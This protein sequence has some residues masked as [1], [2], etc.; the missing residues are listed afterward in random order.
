MTGW[1]SSYKK[2]AI[3]LRKWLVGFFKKN[4]IGNYLTIRTNCFSSYKIGYFQV[5]DFFSSLKQNRFFFIGGFQ[6]FFSGPGCQW[7]D[8]GFHSNNDNNKRHTKPCTFARWPVALKSLMTQFR[9]PVSSFTTQLS[10]F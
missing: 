7:H 6:G 10:R 4:K 3:F 5:A 8:M 9:V 1:F 2:W